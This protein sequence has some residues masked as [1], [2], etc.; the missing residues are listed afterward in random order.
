MLYSGVTLLTPQR[1]SKIIVFAPS[2]NQKEKDTRFQNI[3]KFHTD[4]HAE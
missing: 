2:K 4:R 1:S 3:I